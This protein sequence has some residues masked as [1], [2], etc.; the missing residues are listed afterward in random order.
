VYDVT[1]VGW[2]VRTELF[3]EL[4]KPEYDGV[5]VG[6]A[7]PTRIP[8]GDDAVITSGAA[9]TVKVSITSVAGP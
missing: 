8:E 4:T 5:I 7:S 6:T 9:K 2:V 3:S 1:H